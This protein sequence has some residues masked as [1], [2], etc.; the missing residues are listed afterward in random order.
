MITYTISVHPTAHPQN[1]SGGLPTQKPHGNDGGTPTKLPPVKTAT[2]QTPTT[3]IPRVTTIN[4]CNQTWST[5]INRD[6]DR[7]GTETESMTDAEKTAFCIGGRVSRIEC[8][9]TSG[10]E[11]YSSGEVIV[12]LFNCE[13]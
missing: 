12:P 2:P 6:T 9:T 13:G 10:I 3:T 5:W 1:H 7:D 8:Q 4:P 11:S